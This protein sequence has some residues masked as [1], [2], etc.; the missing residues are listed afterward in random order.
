MCLVDEDEDI[1][2][3]GEVLRDGCLQLADELL[4]RPRPGRV[5]SSE[6]RNFWMSEQISH[7]VD[8][9]RVSSRS[10]PLLVR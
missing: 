1:A 7:S 6:P 5:R 10:M 8:L 9:L 2:L 3:G 4:P